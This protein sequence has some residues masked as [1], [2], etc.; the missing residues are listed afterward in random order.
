MAARA[1]TNSRRVEFFHISPDANIQQL[2][3][4]WHHRFTGKGV[5]VAPSYGAIVGDWFGYV[6]SKKSAKLEELGRG[7]G[8]YKSL[9]V[10]RFSIPQQVVDAC[11]KRYEQ[12]PHGFLYQGRVRNGFRDWGDELWVPEEYLEQVTISGRTT[13]SYEDLVREYQRAAKGSQAWFAAR[14]ETTAVARRIMKTNRVARLY[15]QVIEELRRHRMKGAPLPEY[16][17]AWLEQFRKYFKDDQGG[18]KLR[19]SRD[20]LREAMNL[21][22]EIRI[23]FFPRMTPKTN[24]GTV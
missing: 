14:N 22:N 13:V 9:T 21:E 10:Y 4:R 7:G 17:P 3:G 15:L 24:A 18:M 16:L 8:R 12:S 1:K 23:L 6:A 19:A 11:M 20:E 5:F 2:R